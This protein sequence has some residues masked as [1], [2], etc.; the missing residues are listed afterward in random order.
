MTHSCS[1]S[2]FPHSLG[3]PLF[4]LSEV[5]P[6]SI[7]TELYFFANSLPSFK[8][9]TE[10]APFAPPVFISDISDLRLPLLTQVCNLEPGQEDF[11]S[12]ILAGA[13]SCCSGGLT[14]TDLLTFRAVPRVAVG[15]SFSK[16][17][18]HTPLVIFGTTS[19]VSKVN[20]QA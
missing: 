13:H 1:Y 16:A 3:V 2:C 19:Q 20:F 15:I 11:G 7:L 12:I 17:H 6:P 9:S 14:D 10:C 8:A 4:F 18:T 5:V